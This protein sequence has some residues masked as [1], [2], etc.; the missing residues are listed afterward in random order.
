M[1]HLLVQTFWWSLLMPATIMNDKSK[2]KGR[3]L[4]LG[5]RID[6]RALE[7][8]DPLA[9]N[10]LAVAVQGGGLAVLFR[11]GVVVLFGVAPME[12]TTFLGHLS[13]F[14]VNGYA[15]P[16]T[17][18]VYLQVSSALTDT[19]QGAVVFLP[20]LDIER[21]RIVA[22][23]LAKSVVLSL[24]ESRLARNFDRIEPLAAALEQDGKVRHSAKAL[25][26]HIGNALLSEHTMVGRVEVNE[27]PEIIWELPELEKLYLRLED[28]F[29][30]SERHLALERKLGL[31]SRTAQTLLEVLQNKHSLRVEWYIVILIVV[32]IL[33]TLYDLFFTRI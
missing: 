14:V 11:Y 24:Y 26:Q 29:E 7:T 6:L 8:T 17:E 33:L 15:A 30:I 16:E 18:E 1:P 21:L 31:I 20:T 3:A 32:E 9:V 4:L 10:P 19:M 22:D 28:E 23:I 12:E 2:V 13:Q 25:L 5:E 27:K